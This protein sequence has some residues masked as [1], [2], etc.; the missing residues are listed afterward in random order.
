MRRSLYRNWAP[1]SLALRSANR[2]RCPWWDRH[3]VASLAGLWIATVV[4]AI[5]LMR[6]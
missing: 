5:A 4:I 3:P 6:H 2:R 1:G